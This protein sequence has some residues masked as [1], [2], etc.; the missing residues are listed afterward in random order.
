MSI[1][2]LYLSS[3]ST[4]KRAYNPGHAAACAN[5]L[6]MIQKSVSDSETPLRLGGS[7]IGSRHVLRL[8]VC[9]R[10][11][12]MRSPPRAR[13]KRKVRRAGSRLALACRPSFTFAPSTTPCPCMRALSST[14]YQSP[15]AVAT[16]VCYLHPRT[17]TLKASL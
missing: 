15:V 10:R 13:R 5:L 3:R 7:W 8:S 14:E 9:A 17:R 11:T 4:S 16:A 1:T 2:N 12:R 6:Q